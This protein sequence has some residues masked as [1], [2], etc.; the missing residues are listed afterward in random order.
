MDVFDGK[1]KVKRASSHANARSLCLAFLCINGICFIM[2][3]LRFLLQIN[4]KPPPPSSLPSSTW[5]S[6][7]NLGNSKY[8]F[9]ILFVCHFCVPSN[10]MYSWK[11]KRK[12]GKHFIGHSHPSRQN[13]GIEDE[14]C[15]CVCEWRACARCELFERF[16]CYI[17]EFD[18]N[19]LINIIMLSSNSSIFRIL[20][21]QFHRLM[22]GAKRVRSFVRSHSYY[23]ASSYTYVRMQQS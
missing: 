10:H 18:G 4:I 2:I 17:I 23:K 8:Q 7:T 16:Y 11:K 12:K 1:W 21:P 14:M 3:P 22:R 20:F 9:F 15:S 13:N 19:A 5:N 6:F